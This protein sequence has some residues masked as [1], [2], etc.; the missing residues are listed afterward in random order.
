MNSLRCD[1]CGGQIEMQ[2]DKRGLCLNC[3]TSYSLATMKEM[4]AGVKVSVTGSNEDVEQW[5]QLL[6]R[7]YSAGD[8]IEAERIVK[9]ILEAL[10]D[11]AQAFEKYEQ[12]Q[13]MKYMEIKN[14]VLTGYSGNSAVLV[15]PNIV[16][17]LAPEVFKN[18]KYLEEVVL[19]DGLK[20]IPQGLFSGCERLKIVNISDG[21]ESV[22]TEAFA[23]CSNL[24]EIYMPDSVS[25]IGCTAFSGCKSLKK[26]NLPDGLKIITRNLFAGCSELKEMCIPPAVATIEDGAFVG[27]Q[28]LEKIDIPC[29]VKTIGNN[30][31]S[32]CRSLKK[33]ALYS[34]LERIGTGAFDSTALEEVILP[35]SLEVI[36]DEAFCNCEFLRHLVIPDSVVTL[37]KFA[38]K[39]P[40][41]NCP[42]LENVDFSPR[43][44]PADKCF[45]YHFQGTKFYTKIKERQSAGHCVYCDGPLNFF[46]WCKKCG[47]YNERNV[48]YK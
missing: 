18:N 32:Y 13:V 11:D 28:S 24:D 30:A 45:L 6:D 22:G 23:G 27:C 25:R 47:R 36:G 10:P 20:T 41:R 48:T 8:F 42:N 40:W 14:G 5:R 34:G 9:K 17:E 26:V 38:D 3:G 37:P 35:E 7:Y 19:P 44:L 31:F 15:I 39:F 16:K 46:H 29:N 4:F 21:V 2:P 43:F 12:L 1:I 33:I